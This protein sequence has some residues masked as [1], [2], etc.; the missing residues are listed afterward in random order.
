MY[1]R[2]TFFKRLIYFYLRE[3]HTNTY[4][5]TEGGREGWRDGGREREKEGEGES[6]RE[7][8]HP[9]VHFPD[10]CKDLSWAR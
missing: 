10:S 7:I 8:F 5:Q 4:T 1:G 9:L 6:T 2:K 3:R